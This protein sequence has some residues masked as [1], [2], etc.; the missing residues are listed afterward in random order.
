[1]FRC[2]IST[3]QYSWWQCTKRLSVAPTVKPSYQ[4]HHDPMFEHL[5]PLPE[6]GILN[7]KKRVCRLV[8][9]SLSFEKANTF[10]YFVD[11]LVADEVVLCD[12]TES[13]LIPCREETVTRL[14]N[15]FR[16]VC[17][18]HSTGDIATGNVRDGR[19]LF[20]QITR[21]G[22]NSVVAW[23][24]WWRCDRGYFYHR[25]CTK[26]QYLRGAH[27][28][29][30]LSPD[31]ST[32]ITLRTAS[33]FAEKTHGKRDLR[34][35]WHCR[36]TRC[37]VTSAAIFFPDSMFMVANVQAVFPCFARCNQRYPRSLH[38]TRKLSRPVALAA[39]PII[40]E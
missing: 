36:S 17:E 29:R 19:R 4:P 12:T 20:L 30:N 23:R 25:R 11:V 22:E 40:G 14:E 39:N 24:E 26:V 10:W 34:R 28:S 15:H 35:L 1:M 8:C 21:T 6:K 9:N 37:K 32:V 3:H 33:H 27:S 13:E 31:N 5:I 7:S 16:F 18:M 38:L 2:L